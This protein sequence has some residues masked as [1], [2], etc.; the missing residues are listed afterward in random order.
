MSHAYFILQVLYNE[1]KR[2]QGLVQFLR[3]SGAMETSLPNPFL[4]ILLDR[5]YYYDNIITSTQGGRGLEHPKPPLNTSL[6]TYMHLYLRI[7]DTLK[8][9]G[10]SA[11]IST[12]P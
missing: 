3:L 7:C 9:A 4:V 5:E 2:G 11:S 1:L 6:H 12:L 8:S 10:D